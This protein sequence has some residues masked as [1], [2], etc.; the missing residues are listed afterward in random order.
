[1]S[2][3]TPM[4]SQYMGIKDRHP[5]AI[6]FFRMGDFYEMFFEDAQ[7]ASRM[8]GITLTSRGTH[9]GKK[10]P[11]CGV[12][13]H[14]AKSY[15]AKLVENGLK[16]A[17][18]EQTEDPRTAK[19]IVRREVVRVVTPGSLL[20]EGEI[21]SKSNVY[22]AAISGEEGEYGLAHADLSTGEFRVTEME[23]IE[24]VLD[25]LKRI[26]PA[27]ILIR[28]ESALSESRELSQYRVE[29][30]PKELFERDRAE[31]LLKEQLGVKSL[32]GFGCEEMGG[33]DRRRRRDR[34]LPPGDPE[35]QPRSHQGDRHLSPGRLH[36][37]G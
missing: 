11:M 5:D 30:L 28:R 35:G 10:V 27:E 15:I 36:V 6:L 33:G 1:M 32:A 31:S 19:G 22:M 2:I 9:N 21:D 8:L 18:C 3:V 17:V 12:P 7:T 29:S 24:E 20:E 14:S 4:F 13:H 37:P 34:P 23:R 26:G 16:V 25:E